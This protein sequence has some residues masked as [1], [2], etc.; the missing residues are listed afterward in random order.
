MFSWPSLQFGGE[1]DGLV[2][3]VRLREQ[4]EGTEEP[5]SRKE[6]LHQRVRAEQRR[7][8]LQN[9]SFQRANIAARILKEFQ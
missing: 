7:A 9:R 1:V 4:M 3:Q 8:K 2:M 6:E 5:H